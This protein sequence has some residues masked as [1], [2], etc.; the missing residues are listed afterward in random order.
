M[1][2]TDLYFPYRQI[3]LT[4]NAKQFFSFSTNYYEEEQAKY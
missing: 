4:K 1:R 3:L 2:S